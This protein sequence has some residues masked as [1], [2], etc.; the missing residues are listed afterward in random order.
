VGIKTVL[1]Y[2]RWIRQSFRDRQPWDQFVRELVAANGSTWR[3][4]SVTIYRDRRTPEEITTLVSQLFIG[5][6][7]ECAK[8]HHHPFE[9]WSQD[10]FYSFAGYFAKIGRKGTGISAPISGSEEF[11]FSGT[12]GQVTHPVTGQVMTPR[13]LFGDATPKSADE[14]PRVTLARWITAPENHL[15]S[16]VMANR[17]WADLMARGLVEAV[18][19]FRGTNPPS[20][21]ELMTNLGT[22]FRDSGYSLSALIRLITASHVYQLSSLPSE[23]NVADTRYFSRHYR[24]RLRAEIL[25]DA[26]A[27]IS[28]IPQ[29]FAAVPPDTSA[30]NIWTHRTESLFLD[31]FG[32]PDPNQDP[33]CERTTE[34]TVTQTLHLMNSEQLHRDVISDA[35]NAARLAASESAAVDVV[36]ELYRMIFARKPSEEEL[37]FASELFAAEGASRRQVVED[38]MW[39]M[40]NSPEF[41]LQN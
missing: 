13:P 35:G 27:Q 33:P 38:L 31:T 18:D 19:D 12:S 29:T 2:D 20:N 39:A 28:G 22:A 40:L 32:R 24:H 10:D 26:F 14:D 30:K 41:V 5:V 36:D 4:G 1:N 25:L 3:D 15:F 37:K 9:I 16:Q 21:A 6:R 17:V 11:I 7:L 34:S 23:R 8:C